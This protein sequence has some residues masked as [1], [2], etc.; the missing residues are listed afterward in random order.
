M[1]PLLGKI[2]DDASVAATT[3]IIPHLSGRRAILRFPRMQF[4]NDA[5][6]VE[7]VEYIIV[8]L[9]RLNRYRVAFKS[10]RQR[11]EKIVPRIEDLYN[12]GEYG[13]TG[14]ADGVVLMEKGVVSNPDALDGW[15]KFRR[16]IAQFSDK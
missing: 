2:P 12:S 7:K 13:I 5:R 4:R 8:D 10:D 3:Y 15:E 9:W 6:E 1:R 11:L 14:F 16:E